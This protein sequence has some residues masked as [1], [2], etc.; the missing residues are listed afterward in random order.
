MATVVQRDDVYILNYCTKSVARDNTDARHNYGQYSPGDTR[1]SIAEA[2]RFPVIDSYY[3][4]RSYENSY[5]FNTVTFVFVN[6]NDTARDV[7]VIGTFSD[8]VTPIPMPRVGDSVYCAVSVAVPKGQVHRYRFVVD[9]KTTI[10]PVNPQ[11]VTTPEGTQWSRFF[12]QYCTDIISFERWELTLLLRLTD[13]I[14]PFRTIE[15]Q[16]FLNIYLNNVDRQS[17]D[18]QYA[19][20]YRLDQPIGVVNFIDKI[21]AR[22]ESHRLTDYKVC[23]E[24][25]DRVLRQRDPYEEPAEMPI[26]M[27]DDLYNQMAQDTGVQGWDYSRYSS[28]RYFLQ[29]LRRHTYTG[30]F[31]HP[32]YGGN[33]GA[34]G[35][36]Y[37]AHNLADPVTGALPS[38]ESQ[39]TAFD[40]S[41]ALEKPLGRSPEYHG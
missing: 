15:G 2:W 32:K 35:W 9:G 34:A 8:L 14:L 17:K 24:L 30:A 37:L 5:A 29:L 26:S 13:H 41:R 23:L 27:Y 22:E 6:T 38:A 28:P 21:L 33:A 19:R 11:R 16:R 39:T 36:A 18:T 31:S 3:D 12:T 7:A 40:W 20:A 4:R 1:A 25:I 10:D